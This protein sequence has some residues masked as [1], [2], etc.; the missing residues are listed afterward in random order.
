MDRG[1]DPDY[2]KS[3]LSDAMH[4]AGRAQVSNLFDFG[5]LSGMGKKGLL[6]NAV[7]SCSFPTHLCYIF[8]MALLVL[9]QTPY[10]NL[11]SRNKLAVHE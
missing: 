10:P 3:L 11:L 6:T 7:K 2:F 1:S 5:G 9:C 4:H 8:C